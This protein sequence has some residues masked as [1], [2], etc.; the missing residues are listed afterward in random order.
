MGTIGIT[1]VTV[2]TIDLQ[3]ISVPSASPG[4]WRAERVVTQIKIPLPKADG[5][6]AAQLGGLV[7]LYLFSDLLELR[8]DCHPC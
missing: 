1:I 3:L 2:S 7:E 5:D 6:A 8:E 4:S